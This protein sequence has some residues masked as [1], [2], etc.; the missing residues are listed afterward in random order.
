MIVL[1]VIVAAFV[2][3]SIAI[4][5]GE[6]VHLWTFDGEGREHESDLWIVDVDGVSFLRAN[7][8][9]ARWFVRLQANPNVRVE[10]E[11]SSFAYEAV[12]LSGAPE[13]ERIDRAMAEKYG[14]PEELWTW[15]TRAGETIPIR[16]EP[17][18]PE[19]GSP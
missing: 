7:G 13:K 5:E 10:R 16:L 15:M 9:D 11:G 3:G 12:P 1:A 14:F 19:A 8:P 17:R 4:D 2:V 6:V 18:E